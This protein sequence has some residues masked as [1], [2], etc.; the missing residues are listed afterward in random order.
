[1]DFDN[2]WLR[3]RLKD[4]SAKNNMITLPLL[5]DADGF[6]GHM[7]QEEEVFYILQ[8]VWKKVCTKVPK[9]CVIEYE[10][11]WILCYD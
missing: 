6:T 8:Q 3:G 11:K 7:P 4:S 10:E 1:M 5:N 9:H 2:P